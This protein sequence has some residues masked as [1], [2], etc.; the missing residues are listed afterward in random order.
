[1]GF[2][3][4]VVNS[5]HHGIET[6]LSGSLQLSP[7]PTYLPLGRLLQC[8]IHADYI[9]GT[10]VAS[11]QDVVHSDHERPPPLRTSEE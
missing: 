1:M 3:P 2:D 8:D 10:G 5:S 7:E 9:A 11:Y 6:L 4:P